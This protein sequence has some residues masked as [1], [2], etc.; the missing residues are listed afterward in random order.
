MQSR[1]RTAIAL[2]L[3]AGIA[4]VAHQDAA[5]VTRLEVLRTEPAWPPHTGRPSSPAR[6]A[7]WTRPIRATP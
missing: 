1:C 7:S 5:R 4:A 2:V 6:S 3:A